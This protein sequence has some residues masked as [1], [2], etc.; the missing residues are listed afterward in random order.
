[1]VS[2]MRR[3]WVLVVMLVLLP[4]A[5]PADEGVEERGREAYAL[6]RELMS[7][8]CPGRTLAD[9][10]SPNAAALR[11]EIRDQLAA[12]ASSEEVRADLE[13]RFGDQVRAV[14]RGP[15]VWGIPI[16]VLLAGAIALGVA[17]RRLSSPQGREA[18]AISPELQQEIERELRERGL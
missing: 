18:E 7:P 4:M 9:C 3:G 17:L 10:P 12:G 13:R 6:S 8:Y 14:P 1:M 11:E 5:G 2:L 15:L 16:L